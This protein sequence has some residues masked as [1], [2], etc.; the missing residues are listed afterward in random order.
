[1]KQRLH[2][3]GDWR[4]AF[5]QASPVPVEADNVGELLNHLFG[6]HTPNSLGSGAVADAVVQAISDTPLGAFLN[7]DNVDL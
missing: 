3:I 4:D 1:M 7:R 5:K 2:H 6:I